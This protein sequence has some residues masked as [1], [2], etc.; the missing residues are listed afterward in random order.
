VGLIGQNGCG[1]TT[2]LRLLNGIFPPDAGTITINGRIGALIAVGAGFHPHMTGRENIYLNGTIL[3]M[4][5]QEINRKFDEIVDF[6]EIGDFLDAPVATYS[7][8]MNVRL[9]F[10]IA[11]HGEPD[12][13]LVDEILAVGDTKFQQKCMSKMGDFVDNGNLIIFVS[14]NMLNVQQICKS[15]ILLE[16]GHCIEQGEMLYVVD[17]YNQM[18]SQNTVFVREKL[19]L[20]NVSSFEI[21]YKYLK[22]F[23]NKGEETRLFSTGDDIFFEYSFE[24]EQ[25]LTDVS[26]HIGLSDGPLTHN[27]YSTFYDGIVTKKLSKNTIIKFQ[28][29]NVNLSGG[30]YHV[31]IGIWDKHFIGC[32]F[33]DYE[34]TGNIIIT[35][36]QPMHGKFGFEHEWEIINC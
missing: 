25:E 12:I 28:L 4:T 36:K 22:I 32:Y 21:T 35:S 17:K 7:S 34:S 23:N 11:I 3:G 15:A 29:K 6:A 1:K 19:K 2:L 14:H 16:N 20:K 10:S 31:G 33:H 26:F 5:R 9:G 13:L 24:M 30:T 8:G 18:N 27:A